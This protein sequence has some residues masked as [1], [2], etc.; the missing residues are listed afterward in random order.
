MEAVD[1][2][3]AYYVVPG[4]EDEEFAKNPGVYRVDRAGGTPERIHATRPKEQ[5]MVAAD[6]DGVWI[7]AWSAGTIAKLA[8]TAG[9]K[10]RTIVTGQKG[11]VALAVDATS[12]YW[13]SENTTELR[14]RKK[15]GG[16]IEAIGH[17][18]S[19][20]EVHAVGGDVYW[21]EGDTDKGERLMRLAAGATKAVTLAEGLRG[22]SMRVDSEGVYVNELDRDG[23][24]MFKR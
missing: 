20:E 18:V 14:R 11:I 9:A 12:L 8:K 15:S 22:P 7:G 13:F 17:G 10:A 2:K 1:T 4:F 23:I 21:F 5:F 19:I 24:F 16:A 6:S 3:Y